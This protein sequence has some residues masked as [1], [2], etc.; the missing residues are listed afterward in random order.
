MF[1]IARPGL[2]EKPWLLSN[3]ELK[4]SRGIQA[5]KFFFSQIILSVQL[6]NLNHH[7]LNSFSTSPTRCKDPVTRTCKDHLHVSL[8][9]NPNF[10]RKKKK[11]N[12][13]E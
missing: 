6:Q 12:Q 11:G 4:F 8:V 2:S 9:Q 7:L 13:E 3:N 5:K 1:R 10:R